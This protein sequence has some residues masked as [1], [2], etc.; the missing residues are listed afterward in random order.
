MNFF[1]FIFELFVLLFIFIRFILSEMYYI[2]VDIFNIIIINI[3]K[4]VWYLIRSKF[5]IFKKV[6]RLK[7]RRK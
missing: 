3:I 6:K 4:L 2:V 1:V 7:R 5:N